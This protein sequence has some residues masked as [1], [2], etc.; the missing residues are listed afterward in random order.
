MRKIE[1]KSINSIKSLKKYFII[2]II[3]IINKLYLK[4]NYND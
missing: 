3:F 4:L 1:I 2:F